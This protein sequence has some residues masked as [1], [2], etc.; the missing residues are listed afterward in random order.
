MSIKDGNDKDVVRFSGLWDPF[1]KFA[2][3][4]SVPSFFLGVS[5]A[6]WVTNTNFR[7][8]SEIAVLHANMDEVK[9]R[10][11]GVASQMGKLP[12]KV[13]TAIKSPPSDD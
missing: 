6:V 9:S 7:H 2:L 11:H 12:G 4:L 1:A 5:W 10:L 13:A 3:S 8:D